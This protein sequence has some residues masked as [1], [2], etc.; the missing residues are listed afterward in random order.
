MTAIESILSLLIAALLPLVLSFLTN[1]I[2]PN[3]AQSDWYKQLDKAPWTPPDLAYPFIWILVD[4]MVGVASWL[5]YEYGRANSVSVRTPLLWY[6]GQLLVNI[7][8]DP[9]F[10]GLH[11]IRFSTIQLI[12]LCVLICLT[13]KSF[14]RVNTTAAILFLPYLTWILY[15]TSLFI[16]IWANN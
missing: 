4:L 1:L 5:I 12:A 10:Y 9:I 8:W 3:G 7:I 16:W 2:V 14:Y 6:T 15:L 13:I 11:T